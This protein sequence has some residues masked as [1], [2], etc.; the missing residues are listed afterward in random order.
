MLSLDI[1]LCVILHNN[2]DNNR[3]LQ[4]KKKV[5]A[6]PLEREP[7]APPPERV[8]QA[9]SRASSRSSD[10]APEERHVVPSTVPA[11]LAEPTVTSKDDELKIQGT[12]QVES[13][14]PETA[15]EPAS[16][17]AQPCSSAAQLNEDHPTS[18]EERCDDAGGWGANYDSHWEAQYGGW[19]SQPT[20]DGTESPSAHHTNEDEET[21]ISPSAVNPATS[22]EPL[23]AVRDEQTSPVGNPDDNEKLQDSVPHSETEQAEPAGQPQQ[24]QKEQGTEGPQHQEKAEPVATEDKTVVLTKPNRKSAQGRALYIA[25]KE[26]AKMAAEDELAWARMKVR[27]FSKTSPYESIEQSTDVDFCSIRFT[28]TD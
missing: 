13:G 5:K 4:K 23:T 24:L 12:N 27:N 26:I 21:V 18:V 9:K 6:A 2:N 16:P 20:N 22:F 8:P 19:K 10:T 25:T 11:P 1:D 17:P 28:G 3:K 14:A 7:E 15:P